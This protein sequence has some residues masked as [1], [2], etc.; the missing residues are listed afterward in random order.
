MRILR[1]SVVALLTVSFGVGFGVGFGVVD[2]Y[3][4]DTVR[5]CAYNV[6]RYTA[7]NED[8]RIPQYRTIMEQIRPDLLMCV[9]VADGTMGPRFVADVLTW[10]QYASTPYIDGPDMNAQAYYDQRQFTFVSQRRIRTSLRDIAE[11]VFVTK[12]ASG[13]LA[14]TVV[15]YALHLKASDSQSDAAQRASEVRA[16]MQ[17]MTT[18]KYVVVGGDLN[19]YAPTE[20]A[21]QQLVGS[22]ATPRRFI[23]PLGTVWQRNVS[24]F[25]GMYTQCTRATNIA[26]CGG[27]VTGGIDD[28]FDYLFVSQELEPRTLMNTYTAFGNDGVARLNKAINNPPNQIVSAD[29]A[30]ALLCAS[31]H[32]PVY[33]DVILGDLP[34]SVPLRTTAR[35]TMES[36]T[37]ILT[38]CTPGQMITVHDLVGREVYARPAH[39][40][41][42]RLDL[43]SLKKGLYLITHAGLS[44]R[45]VL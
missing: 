23:D 34:A 29:V 37:A 40:T 1:Y 3:A 4:A 39:D 9:E 30:D 6:L 7:D 22:Q 33:V 43:S 17:S 15:L 25:A 28:R 42:V 38:G 18:A 20:Q 24:A 41:T 26:G 27:G 12:P 32:L 31:D 45:V 21:Y 11:F 13:L 14:D 19:I 35:L 44:Q 8:G 2:S 5:V 16:M 10:G 36:D